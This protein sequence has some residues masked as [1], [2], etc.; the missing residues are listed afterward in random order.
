MPSGETSTTYGGPPKE[1]A[2]SRVA[3]NAFLEGFEGAIGS[4]TRNEGVTDFPE[5]EH[6]EDESTLTTAGKEIVNM[7]SGLA[8]F[9]T[10]R[11]GLLAAFLSTHLR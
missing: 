7:A 2:D 6:R 4:R 1:W 9:G 3:A 10:S 5:M 8:E 11:L